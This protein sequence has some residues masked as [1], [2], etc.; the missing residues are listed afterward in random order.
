MKVVKVK[1]L[2][3]FPVPAFMKVYVLKGMRG[4]EK[5]HYNGRE[6]VELLGL[7]FLGGVLC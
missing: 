3:S 1:S 7:V 2:L 6:R 5:N 4:R